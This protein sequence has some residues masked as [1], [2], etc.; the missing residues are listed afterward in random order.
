MY[1][2]ERRAHGGPVLLS[3]FCPVARLLP[4]LCIWIRHTTR[5]HA[6]AFREMPADIKLLAAHQGPDLSISDMLAR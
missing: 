3:W 6:G 2:A 5:R 4:E 1:D